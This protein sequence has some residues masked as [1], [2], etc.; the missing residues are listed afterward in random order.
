MELVDTL[1]SQT[2]TIEI[3]IIHEPAVKKTTD[4]QAKIQKL[5]KRSQVIGLTLPLPNPFSGTGRKS[6][7]TNINSGRTS[8]PGHSRIPLP[9]VSKRSSSS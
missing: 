2:E 8:L 9:T 4:V 7:L 3:P 6:P 5:E 1:L